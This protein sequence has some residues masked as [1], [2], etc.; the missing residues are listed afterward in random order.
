MVIKCDN[1]FM[2]VQG[3]E[4][5]SNKDVVQEVHEEDKLFNDYK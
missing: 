3:N 1:L 4:A 5:A 2:L